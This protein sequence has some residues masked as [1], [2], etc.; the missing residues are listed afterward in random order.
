M[1]SRARQLESEAAAAETPTGGASQSSTFTW[2]PFQSSFQSLSTAAAMGAS[3]GGG[4][5][6]ARPKLERAWSADKASAIQPPSSRYAH[7]E[8]ILPGS[9]LFGSGVG[10]GSSADYGGSGLVHRGGAGS[11]TGARLLPQLSLE[12]TSSYPGRPAASSNGLSGRRPGVGLFRQRSHDS[13]LPP[14][15]HHHRQQPHLPPSY[16]ASHAPSPVLGLMDTGPS[17]GSRAG[18][19]LPG[20][21]APGSG[22]GLKQRTL[23]RD[24]PLFRRQLSHD[25]AP[26]GS[27]AK[28][29]LQPLQTGV[30]SRSASPTTGIGGVGSLPFASH[31][32]PGH[33]GSVPTIMPM[34]HHQLAQHHH[35][36]GYRSSMRDA[37]TSLPTRSPSPAQKPLAP[38]GHL[39]TGGYPGSGRASPIIR[40]PPQRMLPQL[41]PPYPSPTTLVSHPPGLGPAPSGHGLYPP[42][43]SSHA[44]QLAHP[45]STT[46]SAHF[47][48]SRPNLLVRHSSTEGR[49]VLDR[50]SPPS[51]ST[52]SRLSD[53]D[54]S[55]TELDYDETALLTSRGSR[56]ESPPPISIFRSIC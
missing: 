41:P 15:P 23:P 43:S 50:L 4:A 48:P 18:S 17:A 53:S 46:T 38:P 5:L 28:L 22:P 54:L 52:I 11:S 55:T 26:G 3:G 42:P 10:L 1:A 56:G 21:A 37:W 45:S 19:P 25:S 20:A 9:R 47:H 40:V 24:V 31:P 35:P 44:H 39:A 12:S 34:H 49:Y 8:N 32:Y 13:A 36:R 14:H 7:Q 30:S 33:R 2:R 6:R 29:P 16:P 27:Y 51:T